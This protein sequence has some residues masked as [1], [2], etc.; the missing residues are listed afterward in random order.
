MYSG[1]GAPT[2]IHPS[3]MAALAS[4]GFDVQRRSESSSTW[5][6]RF[7]ESAPPIDLQSKRWD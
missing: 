3:S 7:S 5:I 6:V 4:A 1:G 2:S